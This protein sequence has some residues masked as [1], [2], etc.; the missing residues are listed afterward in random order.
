MGVSDVQKVGVSLIF[1]QNFFY[2]QFSNQS[3]YCVDFTSLINMLTKLV[4]SS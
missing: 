4:K 2:N 1:N 3:F